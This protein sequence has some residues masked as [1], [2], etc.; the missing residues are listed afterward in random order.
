MIS[1]EGYSS[2]FRS[3]GVTNSPVSDT[4]CSLSSSRAS[5]VNSLQSLMEESDRKSALLESDLCV[6]RS[7]NQ[8]LQEEVHR[9]WSVV[10]KLESE[11]KSLKRVV[12]HFINKSAKRLQMAYSDMGTSKNARLHVD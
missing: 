10:D 9:L 3:S 1:D 7:H 5:T 11:N 12:S 8:Q 4:G 2:D 6:E